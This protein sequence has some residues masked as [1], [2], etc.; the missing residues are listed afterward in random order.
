MHFL[1]RK[2]AEEFA[3]SPKTPSNPVE[4]GAHFSEDPSSAL[5]DAAAQDGAPVLAEYVLKEMEAFQERVAEFGKALQ[6]QMS[7]QRSLLEA[8]QREKQRYLRWREE[9]PSHRYDLRSFSDYLATVYM[10][11]VQVAQV[12]DMGRGIF[13]VVDLVPGD[14]VIAEEPLIYAENTEDPSMQEALGVF[15]QS[16][17]VL[18]AIERAEPSILPVFLAQVDAH[19]ADPALALS[20]QKAQ[21]HERLKNLSSSSTDI[22]DVPPVW[23]PDLAP[24]LAPN[25][26]PD[27]APDLAP[28]LAHATQQ[29]DVWE[30][31]IKRR[32]HWLGVI[33]SNAFSLHL[34]PRKA[35]GVF[36][37][38]AML[39]HSCQPNASSYN[40][41]TT[42][43]VQACVP[44]T[45]GQEITHSYLSRPQ[46]P[47]QQRQSWLRERFGFTCRCVACLRDLA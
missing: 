42:M 7:K 21:A 11:K 9:H 37:A 1:D 13:A 14:I 19:Q 44:I 35:V 10:P 16:W 3:V 4:A 27:L 45:K 12:E 38:V 47:V 41:G 5:L 15:V 34:K 31:Q 22:S 23:S 32:T 33:Q 46:S 26:A 39:N 28:A 43:I 20:V 2:I 29:A 36:P 40:E 8:M 25:L 30:A 18:R 24:D 6:A 17:Q